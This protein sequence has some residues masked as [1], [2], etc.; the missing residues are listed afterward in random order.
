VN[1]KQRGTDA[2]RKLAE[3]GELRQIG[4]ELEALGHSGT[5]ENLQAET[6]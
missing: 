1:R 4:K 5:F 6:P 2:A 3:A